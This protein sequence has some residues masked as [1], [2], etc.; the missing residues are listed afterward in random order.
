MLFAFSLFGAYIWN[1]QYL[2][3]WYGNIPEEVTHYLKRTSG[4]WVYLFALNLIV[5]G[6]VPFVVLLSVRAK[7]TPR[8]L[9]AICVFLLCGHSLDPYL[10][11]LPP[12][13]TAPQP[14]PFQIP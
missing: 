1:C 5:N 3:I 12:W 13:F 14:C 2:L 7:C 9:K 10:L 8:G 11:I 4:P 6:V